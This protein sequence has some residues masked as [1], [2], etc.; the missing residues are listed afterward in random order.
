M[1]PSVIHSIWY[2]GWDKIPAKY[3]PYIQS[4]IDKNPGWTIMKWDENSLRDAIASLGDQYLAK[5][6]SMNILHQRID[7]G[8]YA[9]L[10]LYG[11][12]SVD[13]DVVALKG[14]DYTPWFDEKDLIVSKDSSGRW[15]NNATIIA[16]KGNPVIKALIDESTSACRWWE[17]EAVCVLNTTG[18]TFFNKVLNKHKSEIKVLDNEYLEPCSGSNPNCKPTDLS[19]IDHRHEKS[20][21]NPVYKTLESGFYWTK[22]N[23]GLVLIVIAIG[24]G[25]TFLLRKSK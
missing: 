18:I 14:F 15:I 16:S 17:P 24:L 2:Q 11:G 10:Y 12:V 6:N 8:R 7:F 19:I 20:W 5:W 22:N 13:T 23:L 21:I 4:V 25:L 3:Q 9:I 1:I